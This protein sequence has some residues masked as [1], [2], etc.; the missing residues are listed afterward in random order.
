MTKDQKRILELEKEVKELH[1]QFLELAMR[2]IY[3]PYCPPVTTVP[4]YPLNP[5]ITWGGS[6]L[7]TI[8][9]AQSGSITYSGKTDQSFQNQ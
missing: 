5:T 4:N 9:G 8:S 6:N 2:P 3:I 1:K 7:Q